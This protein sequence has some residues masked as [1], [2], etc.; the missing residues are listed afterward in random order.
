MA[1]YPKERNVSGIFYYG[2]AGSDQVLETNSNFTYNSATDTL[3]V[4]NLDGN[5]T[6]ATTAVDASGLTANVT[7]QVSDEM[8]GS[9]TFSDAGDTAN[10]AVTAQAELISNRT[11]ATS[12]RSIDE[13]LILSGT[14]LRRI[15]KGNFVSDLGGG[16][17]SS[18]QL[19]GDS[20]PSQTVD[21]GDTVAVLGG[22]GLSTVTTAGENVTVNITGIDSTMIVDGQILNADLANSSVTVQCD[23]GSAA[24]LSLGE[25]LDIGGGSGI[26][27]TVAGGSPEQVTVN[28]TQTAVTAGSYGSASQVGTFTVDANGRLTAASNVSIDGSSI[29]NNT[30]TIAADVGSTDTVALTETLTI[31]GGS[32]IETNRDANNQIT[33]NQ[34]LTVSSGTVAD[35]STLASDVNVIDVSAAARSVGLPATPPPGQVVRVK[36]GDSSANTITITGAAGKPIDGGS[37]YI[38]YNQWESIT[39]VCDNDG[40][41]IF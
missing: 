9:A 4:G 14:E 38:L 22:T 29:S 3:N 19:D 21:D 25:T 30:I 12:G 11:V 35:N 20:G 31:A 6:T 13:I 18:W 33:I 32:G 26:S 10:V 34:V 8:A 15:T 2:D 37:S 41:Y 16:S 23:V 5:A 17:M 39:L 36:K 24:T 28:L 40:W 27:T 7:V 1:Y